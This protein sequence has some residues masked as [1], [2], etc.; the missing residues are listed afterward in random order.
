MYVDVAKN[1]RHYNRIL[2]VGP[3]WKMAFFKIGYDTELTIGLADK[4]L[5]FL[6]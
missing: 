4:Y 6:I 5:F 2:M 1:R 3:R